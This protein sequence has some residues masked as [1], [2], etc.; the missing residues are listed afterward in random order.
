MANANGG[1]RTKWLWIILLAALAVLLLVWL[2]NPAGDEDDGSVDDPI[3]TPDLTEPVT[4]EAETLD[5]PL[6]PGEG[7]MEAP[8]DTDAQTTATG[9]DT[10]D[11]ME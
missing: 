1:S 9:T 5:E 11:T 7:A 2:I 10:V 6:V 8:T 4:T 3:V